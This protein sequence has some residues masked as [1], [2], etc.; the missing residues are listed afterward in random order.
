MKLIAM[1]FALAILTAC[2]ATPGKIS[3]T[4]PV[5]PLNL[6]QGVAIRGYDPVAYFDTGAPIVGNPAIKYEWQGATW[7]F[8]TTAH[9]DAFS[10]DPQ[11]YAPQYG[12]YCAYAVSRGTTADADPHQWAVVDGKLFLNNNALAKKLWD[13][14]RPGNIKAG[15]ENWPLIPKEASTH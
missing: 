10:A 2:A 3:Q 6:R 1:W 4:I 9:R 8:A 15:D 12:G 11:H 13:Q 14:D 5:A 7:L